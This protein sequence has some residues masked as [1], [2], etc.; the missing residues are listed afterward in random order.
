[1]EIGPSSDSIQAEN[2][3]GSG[4]HIELPFVGYY[5]GC[6]PCEMRSGVGGQVDDLV[7][8]LLIR[9]SNRHGLCFAYPNTKHTRVRHASTIM[10]VSDQ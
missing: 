8:V 2:A 3:I 4:E 1:M 7:V 6:V 5:G 9:P 10:V